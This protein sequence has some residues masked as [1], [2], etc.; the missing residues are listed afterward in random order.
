MLSLGVAG[1]YISRIYLEV[2]NRP[3]YIVDETNIIPKFNEK[4][5]VNID[6]FRYNLNIMALIIVL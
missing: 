2:K 1:E 3:I 4:S 6:F 5:L